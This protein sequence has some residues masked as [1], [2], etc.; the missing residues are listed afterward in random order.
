M[1]L[2]LVCI[3]CRQI[4]FSIQNDTEIEPGIQMHT[5]SL[6]VTDL[7]GTNS[8]KPVEVNITL[9]NDQQPSISLPED[10][11]TFIEGSSPLQLFTIAPNIT[12]PDDSPYQRSIITCALLCPNY[13][14][15][16]FEELSFN[17]SSLNNVIEGSM[18]NDCLLLSG[19]ATIED[20]E[21]VCCNGQI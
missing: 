12:D 10:I 13:H 14:D 17:S 16:D 5:I 7:F 1:L 18:D 4:S 11:V 2:L 19:N 21:E 6:T 3:I 9:V 15:P 8:S 20:Y